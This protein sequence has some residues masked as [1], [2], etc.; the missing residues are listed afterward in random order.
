VIGARIARVGGLLGLAVG[1]IFVCL[2]FG[3]GIVDSSGYAARVRIL[4][5]FGLLLS[6]VTFAYG[7]VAPRIHGDPPNI[8]LIFLGV[9]SPLL[10]LIV[11][12]ELVFGLVWA[13]SR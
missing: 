10:P 13:A 2:A 12:W 8:I 1:I 11:Q 4:G 6:A 7:V 5:I 9:A 3:I